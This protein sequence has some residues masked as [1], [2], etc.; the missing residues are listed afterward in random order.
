M[1]SVVSRGRGITV[2]FA[3]EHA[4]LSDRLVPAAFS[5]VESGE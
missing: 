4:S 1:V 3:R 2:S 5:L